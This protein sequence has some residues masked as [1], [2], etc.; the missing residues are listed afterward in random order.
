[1]DAIEFMQAADILRVDIKPA[2]DASMNS[3]TSLG[4][5]IVTLI[6]EILKLE[7]E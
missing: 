4:L 1:M 3:I 2:V 5:P 6:K 7:N